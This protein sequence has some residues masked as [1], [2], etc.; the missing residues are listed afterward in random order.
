[1]KPHPRIRKTIKW[2]CAAVTVLLVVVWIGSG[3]GYASWS[4]PRGDHAAV[5]GGMARVRF[6]LD[7]QV[8]RNPPPLA[9]GEDRRRQW[10]GPAGWDWRFRFDGTP[11]HESRFEFRAI[12]GFELVDVPIW[13]LPVCTGAMWLW[14]WRRDLVTRYRNSVKHCPKCNYDR[15][16]LASGAVCPECGSRGGGGGSGGVPS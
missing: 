2:G 16:G 12:D 5:F 9:P 13:P 15:T 6:V 7:E 1:M 11:R 10:I 8:V 3:W 4:S 14:A